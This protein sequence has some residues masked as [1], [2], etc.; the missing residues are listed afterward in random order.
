MTADAVGG[1]WTY[2]AELVRALTDAQVTLAVLGPSPSELQRRQVGGARLI[3]TQLALDWMADT[4]AQVLAAADALRRLADDIRPDVVHLNSPALA[5]GSGGYG[6]PTLGV[7]HSC[8]ATWWAAVKSG[9]LPDDFGWRTRL[10]R[11]GLASCDLVAA[12]SSSFAA[13]VATTYDAKAVAI[14]NGRQPRAASS[15]PRDP[16]VFTAGRLWDEGK[17][18]K[19]IDRA[20]A[21]SRAPVF[22]AGPLASPDGDAAVGLEHAIPLG[23]L[24]SG[25]VA[26]WMARASIFASAAR[27]EPFGLA[28]LEAAQAG[29]ALVLSDIPTFRE[30]WDG[31]AQFIDPADADG[32]A[33]AFDQLAADPAEAARRGSLA[34]TRAARFSADAMAAATLGH[35]RRLLRER[36]A[37]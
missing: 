23:C 24:S 5:A 8:V 25:A 36:V 37:A 26:D 28:V 21:L 4:P 7:C 16:I 6:A 34:R 35:Y 10:V 27:Y 18:A 12:P 1:I 2:A 22:A 15:G 17:N 20:A 33:S 14:Y 30:L 13:A 31:A 9:P 19:T 29:C 11:E 32:F 3:D